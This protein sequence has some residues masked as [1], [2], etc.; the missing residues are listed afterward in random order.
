MVVS[1]IGESHRSRITLTAKTMWKS[2]PSHHTCQQMTLQ[3]PTVW[4]QTA[5]PMLAACK[6]ARTERS[7][8]DLESSSPMTAVLFLGPLMRLVR[9]L[10]GYLIFDTPLFH[11]MQVMQT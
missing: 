9:F 6:A 3:Q 11:W 7:F 4:P 8:C 2:P 5:L 10:Y 1:S